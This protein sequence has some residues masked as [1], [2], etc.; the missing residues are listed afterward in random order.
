M[1]DSVDADAAPRV[2]ACGD[3]EVV[4]RTYDNHRSQDRQILLGMKMEGQVG[5]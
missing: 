4:V 5:S 3:W 1:F 2:F